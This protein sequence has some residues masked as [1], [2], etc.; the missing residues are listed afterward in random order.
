M[1]VDVLGDCRRAGSV[2]YGRGD[3]V[4][5]GASVLPSG[6]AHAVR[7][8]KPADVRGRLGHFSCFIEP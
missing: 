7:V 1:Q 2:S 4:T 8:V 3:H 6:G 5:T